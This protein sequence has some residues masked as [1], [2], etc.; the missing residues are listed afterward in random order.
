MAFLISLTRCAVNSP[1]SQCSPNMVDQRGHAPAGPWRVVRKGCCL[2]TPFSDNAG[3][4]R[5]HKG[6]FATLIGR[7][8]FSER[9][10]RPICQS[11]KTP[12]YCWPTPFKVLGVLFLG[13]VC[14]AFLPSKKACWAY[15][16]RYLEVSQQY[17]PDICD[18]PVEDRWL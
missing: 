8:P 18:F 1:H 13:E 7:S 6:V 4:L 11:R 17:P 2:K 10:F 12:G 15:Q 9:L 16:F 3:C 5:L 14:S